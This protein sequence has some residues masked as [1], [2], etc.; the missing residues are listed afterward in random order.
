MENRILRHTDIKVSALCLG[1]MTFGEQNTPQESH[2]IMDFAL[3]NGINFFDTAE[4]YPIPPKEETHFRTEEIIGRWSQFQA[5]RDKV[6]LATKIIGPSSFMTYIRNG[7]PNIK[8]SLR[9]ALNGSLKRLNTDYIDL[10][11]IHWPAR[12]TNYFGQ[13]GYSYPETMQSDQIMETTYELEKFKKEGL[14]RSYG[15]SNESPWGMMKYQEITKKEKLTGISTIQ[16]PYSLLNRTFEIGMSEVC[17]REEI[18]LL[19]YSPLGFGVLT[20]KYIENRSSPQDRLNRWPDYKRYNNP[21]AI[22]ATKKY[23]EL[24]K[25]HGISLTHMALQFVTN[26]PFVLSN[27]I[28]ATNIIQLKENI[29][30]VETALSSELLEE[31]DQIHM[32]SPN[33]SP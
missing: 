15:V 10:Y 4:M 11:Q 25:S 22:E 31:I 9:E 3:D 21:A 28:G 7:S 12:V 14:I 2:E 16:N 24:A 19:P 18:Q 1:T 13:L 6:I 23:N 29:D 8:D 27:I 30:S 5:S 32:L 33:P 26:R 20:G 17:H